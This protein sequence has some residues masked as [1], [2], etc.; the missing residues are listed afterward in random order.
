MVLRALSL[1]IPLLAASPAAA[2]L[3]LLMIE[4]PGCVYGSRHLGSPSDGW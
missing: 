2:E 1:V 4:Q 3:T